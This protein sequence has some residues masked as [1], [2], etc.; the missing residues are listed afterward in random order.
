MP[1]VYTCDATNIL[2]PDLILSA[3]PATLEVINAILVSNTDDSG[4]GSFR[5]AIEYSNLN[6]GRD[7]MVFNILGEGVSN[8]CTINAIANNTDPLVMDGYTQPGTAKATESTPATLLIELDGINLIGDSYT[9]G[10]TIHGGNS[11]IRGLIINRFGDDGIHIADIGGNIIEGN[12]IG[13][14]AS[15]QAKPNADGALRIWNSPDNIIGGDLAEQRNVMAGSGSHIIQMLLIESASNIIKGNYIGVGPNG[16]TEIGT[17]GVGILINNQAHHNII[18]PNNVISGNDWAGISFEHNNPNNNSVIGNFIGTNANGTVSVANGDGIRMLGSSYNTIGGSFESNRNLISGNI[19]FGI[20]IADSSHGN[21]IYGNYIGIMPDGTTALPNGAHGISINGSPD[22]TV[23]GTEPGEGNLISGNGWCGLEIIAGNAKGNFVS[24]NM[25]GTNASGD[26]AVSNG[27]NGVQIILDASENIIGPGN[28]ISGNI[29]NGIHI[30][31]EG[32]TNNIVVGNL[33]GT[34]VDGLDALGN[35]SNGINV[36]GSASN[37]IGGTTI[38]E[39]NI[40]SGNQT[41]IWIRG[42]DASNNTITG[43]YIGTDINGTSALGNGWGIYVYS[44]ST[45]IGGT[46]DGAG[47]VISG[48]INQGLNIIS[49]PNLGIHARD[50]IVLGNIIGL[51]A[52]GSSRLGNGLG[53]MVVNSPFNNIGGPTA[54]HRNIISGNE[55]QGLYIGWMGATGNRVIGNYIG[56][57]IDGTQ[58]IGNGSEGILL[59][60]PDNIIGGDQQ[61]YGNLVSGNQ[62]GIRLKDSADFNHIIGNYVGLQ[63]SGNAPLGNQV[64]GIAIASDTNEVR[65]NV[66]SGNGGDEQN[67]GIVIL[68]GGTANKL[69]GNFI[70]T[71]AGWNSSDQK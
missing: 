6:E 68:D 8:N 48:N 62:T 7:S 60:G 57:N 40:I 45:I 37:T 13:I 34:A 1:G 65:A 25:I 59:N 14:D 30:E 3:D 51:D 46:Q 52:T 5:N 49:N 35:G 9:S 32:A 27:E 17:S 61:G 54:A 36:V 47:N 16:D 33:I 28:I 55:A 29:N 71:N 11:I 70:G 43:N 38:A 50:N 67:P 12:Y 10:L 58:S 64:F 56:T 22:N 44:D 21:N 63:A 39:R 26:G 4:P 42:S 2:A 53:L 23:G 31:S 41:G 18:G 20:A 19:N 24:N 69:T 66:V 15:G